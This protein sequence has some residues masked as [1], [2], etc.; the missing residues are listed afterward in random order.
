MEV[1]LSGSCSCT[2]P[3]S[4]SVRCTFLAGVLPSRMPGP[5]AP[6][7]SSTQHTC[8]ARTLAPQRTRRPAHTHAYTSC[9]GIS[10]T[11]TRPAPSWVAQSS[12]ESPKAVGNHPG[13]LP[14][15]RVALLGRK[16]FCLRL[17]RARD[18]QTHRHT[19]YCSRP[20]SS[21]SVLLVCTAY[22]SSC[23]LRCPLLCLRSFSVP[24]INR[25]WINFSFDD[26]SLIRAARRRYPAPRQHLLRVLYCAQP[27]PVGV[28][29]HP[30]QSTVNTLVCSHRRFCMSCR[31][32]HVHVS[33]LQMMRCVQFLLSFNLITAVCCL[34]PWG[35]Q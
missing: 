7:A 20:S 25:S 22:Q 28:S 1:D 34:L 29:N 6:V 11:R 12:F 27:R 33:M 15:L 30:L 23:P 10:S 9:D 31:H 14:V 8:P 18:S 3:S 4:S 16:S 24:T 2:F 5:H 17:P 13:V 21:A 32:S 19:Y 26:Q 35:L